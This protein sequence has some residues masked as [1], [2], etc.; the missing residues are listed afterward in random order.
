MGVLDR[1]KALFRRGRPLFNLRISPAYGIKASRQNPYFQALE[2]S[3]AALGLF[4]DFVV[5]EDG[6]L[7]KGHDERLPTRSAELYLDAYPNPAALEGRTVANYDDPTA[8]RRRP[9]LALEMDDETELFVVFE[10]QRLRVSGPALAAAREKRTGGSR[11]GHR[12][13]GQARG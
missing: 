5:E 9:R 2:R 1:L 7:R 13:R 8:P 12:L 6:L 4:G 10:G 3:A 11:S